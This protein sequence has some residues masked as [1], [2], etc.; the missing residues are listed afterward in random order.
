MSERYDVAIIGA[1]MS[2]LAAGIR[3]AYFGKRVCIFER[4]NAPGG[5]NSFYSIDGRKYDVGLHALTNFVPPSVKG[6]PLGRILRQLRIDRDELDL[7]SQLG[8]RVA[9]PGRTLR[10]TNDVSILESEVAREF[11]NQVDAYRSFMKAIREYDDNRLDPPRESARA[12][13][14]AYI[15]DPVLTDMLLCPLMF[16]GSAQEN[17]MDLLQFVIMAKSIFLEGFARPLEGVRRIIR[18]LLDRFR[19]AGGERRMKCGVERIISRAGRVDRL[20][21]DSGEEV[22]AEHVLSSIGFPETMLL[23]GETDRSRVDLNTGRL[24]FVETISV[25]QNQPASWGW[26][27]DTIVFFNDSDRFAYEAAREHV[28]VR[29]GIIC[30]PN[31]F[32]YG[33]R[34]LDE[35]FVR[36]TCLA[37]PAYWFNAPENEYVA[38]K[39]NWFARIE[40]SARRF[41][42]PPASDPGASRVATDM[43]TPRT[44]RHFTGHLNGAIYGAPEKQRTGRTELQNLFLCGTDQGFLGIIGA[45]LS[46]IT[47]ANLNILQPGK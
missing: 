13:I 44:V 14:A 22:E 11:P 17:D 34:R 4:H 16:Y 24:G 31:N 47:M 25:Y 45:I 21:L 9:F 30:I 41:M 5:L 27:D 12:F 15:S 35:G 1:G 26:G 29:S 23:C 43:F 20:V 3:L 18:V 33:D 8:S 37:D 42:P 38:E 2:G 19:A 36:V 7:C 40:A 46:G 39:K 28:D 32:D 6:T 10:F